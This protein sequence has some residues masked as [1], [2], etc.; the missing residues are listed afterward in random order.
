[1]PGKNITDAYLRRTLTLLRGA[2]GEAIQSA[3]ALK[4]IHE[5]IIKEIEKLSPNAT[6]SQVKKIEAD[7]LKKLKSFYKGEF[8]TELQSISSEVVAK[9]II[10]NE[11][12]LS[13]VTKEKLISPRSKIVSD[14]AIKKKY[15]G[16][17]FEK[18]IDRSFGRESKKIQRTLRTSFLEGKSI[19]QMTSDV[20]RIFPRP[21]AD[22]K[23]ITRSFFMHNAVEA[24][25]SVFNLNP[26]V[27][28]GR[29]WLSTLDSRT[30]PLI[31]G[32]R[33]EKEYDNNLDPVGHGISWDAGP[34]R[35]H[36]NC[37]STSIPKVKGVSFVAP[38]PSVG[39]GKDYARG[40]NKTRTGKVRKPSKKNIDDGTFKRQIKTTRTK[41]EGWLRDQ[42][43]HNI[44][45][46]S[47]VLG[48]KEKAR[49]FRDGKK[50][51][52]Q[53]S[54]E[55]PVANALNRKSI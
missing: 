32:V 30:T 31:C 52:L 13:G 3:Q 44:D 11:N 22:V 51:L 39:A 20:R 6:L 15:Q 33:D 49:L 12:F 18:W 7:V 29:V 38:R 54:A 53:L 47:D 45:Y 43:R 2:E 27:V 14:A 21:V 26:D 36:W 48:S 24:K 8:P 25:E 50:T 55:S 34:G 40:D 37:R 4:K 46:V 5:L 35:I 10:W 23:T 42:S 9:E 16:K 1:M 28:E 41:Y 19:Q 17:T